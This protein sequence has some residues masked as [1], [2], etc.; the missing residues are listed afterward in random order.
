MLIEVEIKNR[1][2]GGSNVDLCNLILR[3]IEQARKE[4]KGNEIKM[5]VDG[6]IDINATLHLPLVKRKIS[7]LSRM[8]IKRQI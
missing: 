3:I 6:R 2:A 4:V 1:A 5:T 8:I 7:R